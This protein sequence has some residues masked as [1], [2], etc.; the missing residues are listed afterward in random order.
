MTEVATTS[1]AAAK[2]LSRHVSIER[3]DL[4]PS[5]R[6]GSESS[7]IMNTSST[8]NT[9]TPTK[10]VMCDKSCQTSFP[11]LDSDSHTI[12]CASSRAGAVT[13]SPASTDAAMAL[14]SLAFSSA[15]RTFWGGP[16]PPQPFPRSNS[17][18][19]KTNNGSDWM[20]P[21]HSGAPIETSRKSQVF[22]DSAI[23][24]SMTSKEQP[25]QTPRPAPL[26]LAPITNF[27]QPIPMSTKSYTPKN[28]SYRF[29]Y[30]LPTSH[31]ASSTKPNA[32]PAE[33][34]HHLVT[35]T[36][37]KMK[38]SP[39]DTTHDESYS[40]KS[41]SLGLLCEN[42]CRENWEDGI[43]GIDEAAKLLGVERRRI[44]DI[45]NILE[46]LEIVQRKCK[47]RYH[48][49]GF[50][51]LPTVLSEIQSQAIEE[52]TDEAREN[53]I[54][55]DSDVNPKLSKDK[56]TSSTTNN[57]TKKSLGRL[58]RQFLQLF[59]VG[60]KVMSLTEASDRIM[61][62]ADDA[63]CCD[64]NDKKAALTRGQ[65]TKIRR[66]YDI[67]NVL[68]SIGLVQKLGNQRKARPTFSW[69]YQWSALKIRGLATSSPSSSPMNET[70]SVLS[71]IH[72][73][74]AGSEQNAPFPKQQP[75]K[76][77]STTA[78]KSA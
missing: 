14:S 61:G 57:S 17:A 18:P 37:K 36:P 62:K 1:I 5:S 44:Y 28:P 15:R 4:L 32:R 65:K 7:L 19:P 30:K 58:S 53:G 60:N 68:A 72:E 51:R 73:H 12:I 50:S 25:M 76:L 26:V 33:D 71:N 77:F 22:P 63:P 46:S 55:K 38:M 43:I 21:P 16:P 10:K 42:F 75:S 69:V 70:K 52:L 66:L 2:Q 67:A 29:R 11:I 54:L 40:R 41:K 74:G 24:S 47:N 13:A 35:P 27:V 64:L 3:G 49:Q 31:T 8:T 34:N 56:D 78:I 39:S 20:R 59:L 45:I 6:A 48:W 23:K 9:S